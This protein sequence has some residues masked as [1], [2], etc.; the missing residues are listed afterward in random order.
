MNFP[1]MEK[2]IRSRVIKEYMRAAGYTKA[3]C[4]TCGNS[5]AALRRIRVPVLVVSEREGDLKPGRWWTPAEIR[6]AWPGWFDATSGHLPA[7]LMVQ[8]AEDMR[9]TVGPLGRGPIDIPTGSGETLAVMRWAYPSTEFRPIQDSDAGTAR[10]PEQ[11][12]R[13]IIEAII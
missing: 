12:L 10:H 8:I 5:G 11:P 7:H 13:M 2:T 4:F 9:K 6:R 1:L 3:V